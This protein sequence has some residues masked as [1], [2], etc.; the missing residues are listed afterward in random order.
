MESV[1]SNGATMR[2]GYGLADLITR[3]V[4]DLFMNPPQNHLV[5]FL[6]QSGNLLTFEKC[7]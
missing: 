7:R 6:K 4:G 3:E 5:T 1:L 2:P